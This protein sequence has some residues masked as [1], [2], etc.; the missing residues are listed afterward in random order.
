M[1]KFIR[2]FDLVPIFAII[3]KNA[4]SPGSYPEKTVGVNGETA[5]I[6]RG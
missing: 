2:E 6:A 3:G 1:W 5:D 4:L